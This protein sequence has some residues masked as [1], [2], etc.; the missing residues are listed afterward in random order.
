MSDQPAREEGPML[1]V[2][3]MVLSVAGLCVPPMLL[4]TLGLGL[5]G[6]L[7]GRRDAKW[8]LR[9][10]VTQMTMAVSGAGIIIFLGLG[11]PNFKRYQMRTRQLECRETLSEL[12]AAQQKF[13][14]REKRYTTK[15]SELLPAPQRG[16]VLLRLAPEGALWT[17][18]LP[19]AEQVGQGFDE[20]KY[21][22]LSTRAVD[23]ALPKLVVHELGIKGDCP[24]CSVTML[25]ATNL[26]G[27][28]MV[29]VWTVSTIERLGDRGEHIAG[30]LPWNE[31]D[32]VSE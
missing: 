25:C 29:D 3:A 14:A 30:G 12:H 5:Y 24:A 13:Y 22:Q 10:Q 16:E 4:I 11:L 27:D 28:A 1:P 15:L 20:A 8:A 7:R 23:E 19:T 17:G 2:V 18:G 6:Y 21:P 32:D 9:K 26:D 31:I